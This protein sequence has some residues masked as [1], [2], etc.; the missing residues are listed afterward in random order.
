MENN[1]K[2]KNDSKEIALNKEELKW[3]VKEVEK[4]G[5]PTGYD[6]WEGLEDKVLKCPSVQF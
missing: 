5:A 6:S 4:S 2:E 1:K 3:K